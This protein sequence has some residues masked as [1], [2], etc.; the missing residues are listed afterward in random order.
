MDHG[1]ACRTAFSKS[2]AKHSTQRHRIVGICHVLALCFR[3]ATGKLDQPYVG[4]HGGRI[5]PVQCPQVARPV[6]VRFSASGCQGP[7][8]PPNPPSPLRPLEPG[9]LTRALADDVVAH[10]TLS[11]PVAGGR[12]Q[13]SIPSTDLLLKGLSFNDWQSQTTTAS[14]G[15]W[16]G[17]RLIL[18]VPGPGG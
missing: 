8:N 7:P 6:P 18:A 1:W 14:F 2:T 11:W 17:H 12:Y 3:A 5:V 4:G 15:V 16:S 9:C 10:R 13:V